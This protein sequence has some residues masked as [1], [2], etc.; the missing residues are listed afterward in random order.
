MGLREK[1]AL[2]TREG[3][4]R[5][6]MTLF[7]A[8]GF[9]QTTVESIAERVEIS[10]STL[11]RYF[12]SKDLIVLAEFDISIGR[13]IVEF[14]ARPESEPIAASLAASIHAVIRIE[15]QQPERSRLVRSIL[16]QSPAARAKLWD[17]L[18][19]IQQGLGALIAKRLA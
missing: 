7:A 9:E 1:K 5:E 4:I 12:P 16:D 18:A 2:K 8:N 15:D 19:D 13:L 11:Y 14:A 10:P 6:A 17:R 3:I